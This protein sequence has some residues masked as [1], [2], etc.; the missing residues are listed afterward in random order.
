MRLVLLLLALAGSW[1][2]TPV[3]AAGPSSQGL[4]PWFK[5]SFLDL[6]EDVAEAAAEGRRLMVYFHQ[7]GCPYCQKLLRDNFG[8]KA[9]AEKTRAGFQVVAIDIWGDREVVGLG[10]DIH[11]EKSFARALQVQFTPTLLLLDES[12]RVVLRINGYYPPHLFAL[13]LDYAAPGRHPTRPFRDYLQERAPEAASGRLYLEHGDL[14]PP[15]DLR[16][17][18]GDDRHLLVLF[19]QRECTA[20]DELHQD[21]WPRQP[22]STLLPRFRKVVLDMWSG[23]SLRTPDGQRLSINDWARSL[24]VRY[25]PTFVFFDDRGR[26]VFRTEAYLKT[27]HLVSVL[28]YVASNAYLQEPQFQRFLLQR[29]DG[30][31]DAGAKVE[32]W[33]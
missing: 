31:R 1:P 32:L 13:A 20:C 30:L 26:E 4:L 16:P 9:I 3:S 18:D 27:F 6:R 8:Q 7:N 23:E 33:D 12:A 22:V 29:T 25:A 24:G 2:L 10:G 28:Q 17:A 5:M 11:T 19:E 15:L 14:E 21:I